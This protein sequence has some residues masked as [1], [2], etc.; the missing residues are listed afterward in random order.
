MVRLSSYRV[1]YSKFHQIRNFFFLIERK[2]FMRWKETQAINEGGGGG[3]RT[4]K[5]Q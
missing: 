1:N 2:L 4:A 3:T 5:R